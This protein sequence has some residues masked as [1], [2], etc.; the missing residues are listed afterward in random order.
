[1]AGD[2]VLTP[3]TPSVTGWPI[4]PDVDTRKPSPA[5]DSPWRSAIAFVVLTAFVGHFWT[6]IKLTQAVAE[7]YVFGPMRM[8]R[9]VPGSPG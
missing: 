8:P 1:M 7:R 4:T 6:L 5:T 2:C 9:G 3:A